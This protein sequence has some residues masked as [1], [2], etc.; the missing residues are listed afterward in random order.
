MKPV[1]EATH[2]QIAA[3]KCPWCKEVLGEVDSENAAETVWNVDAMAAALDDENPSIR[4]ITVTNLAGS[5]LS[6]DV[7][8]P[9]FSKALKENSGRDS[10][11][12]E[13]T[14]EHLGRQ[15]PADEVSRIE[16]KIAGSPNELALRI[17]VLPSYFSGQRESDAVRERRNEH[18]FWLIQHAPDSHTAGTPYAWID[19]RRDAQAYDKAKQLWLQQVET[20][21]NRAKIHGNAAGLFTLQDMSLSESLLQKA[22]DLEPANPEWADRL[23]HLYSLES[24]RNSGEGRTKAAKAF[25]ALAVAQELRDREAPPTDESGKEMSDEEKRS[26]ALLMAI[27]KLPD[28]AKAA[29]AA[30]EFEQARNYATELLQKATSSELPEFF[31][32]DGNAIHYANLILGRLS[33][34]EGDVES[35]KQYLIASGKTQGSPNLGSFGPNMSLAKELL[36]RG[37][38][39]TVLRYFELC[40]KFWNSHGEVLDRWTEDVRAG[41]NPQFGA[42]LVY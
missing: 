13:T 23:G 17:L 37:E 19:Q 32:N 20:H 2:P 10:H 6:F 30:S 36:E 5:G 29:F 35:A 15:L 26:H 39:E 8:L 27:W 42:N 1:C 21:P 34:R 41:R 3:G 25:E 9:L 4:S 12:A 40:R 24:R 18:I 33:F 7:M 28:L 22:R 31:R 11:V 14:L 16:E 38:Q